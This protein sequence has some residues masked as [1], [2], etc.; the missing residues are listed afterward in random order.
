EDRPDDVLRWY[1]LMNKERGRAGHA[2]HG[3]DVYSGKIAD[4]VVKTHPERALEIYRRLAE[5]HIARTS[6]SAYESALPCLRKQRDLLRK[7]GR[8]GEWTTYLARLRE[9]N[10][11]KRRLLELL[12]GL[13]GKPIL[14]G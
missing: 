7:L 13:E 6:P 11:R 12:D 4:A 5:G 8:A 1:D 10:R 9:D 2:F 14:D 3:M